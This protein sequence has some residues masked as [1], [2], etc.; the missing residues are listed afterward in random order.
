M[1]PNPERITTE[2]YWGMVAIRR[3]LN[4]NVTKSR[5]EYGQRS[6]P[7]ETN[8]QGNVKKMLENLERNI[9]GRPWEMLEILTKFDIECDEEYS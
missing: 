7:N 6:V 2:N 3:N 8:P 1:W 4:E 5:E 9:Y